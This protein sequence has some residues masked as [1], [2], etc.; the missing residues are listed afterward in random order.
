MTG[1]E[2][3]GFLHH[4]HDQVTAVCG[5][6]QLALKTLSDDSPQ[7]DYLNTVLHIAQRS[8]HHIQDRRRGQQEVIGEPGRRCE[9]HPHMGSP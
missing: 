5:W 4:L 9:A 1:D 3:D 6:T 7:R 2:L 8:A